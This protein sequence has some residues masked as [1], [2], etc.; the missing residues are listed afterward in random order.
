MS[1]CCGAHPP[2][3]SRQELYEHRR[4]EREIETDHPAQLGELG[5][6]HPER[7]PYVRDLLAVIGE[8]FHYRFLDLVF[9]SATSGLVAVR[10]VT[11][12]YRALA[13]ASA[14]SSVNP[15]PFRQTYANPLIAEQIRR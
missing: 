1:Q 5:V 10:L 15:T 2:R 3:L 11:A 8:L 13:C 14:C 6:Q 9:A 7:L 4:R 12:P